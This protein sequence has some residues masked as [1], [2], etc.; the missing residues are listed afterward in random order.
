[1]GMTDQ[2]QQHMNFFGRKNQK[3]AREETFV[4]KLVE[5]QE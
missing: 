5:K 2:G 3:E 1:M 4:Q